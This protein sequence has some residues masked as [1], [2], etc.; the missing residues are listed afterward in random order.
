MTLNTVADS[1]PDEDPDLYMLGLGAT[2][3]GY[4][5]NYSQSVYG[6]AHDQFSM[7]VL[8]GLTKHRGSVM[9]R[10]TDPRDTPVINFRFFGDKKPGEQIDDPHSSDL[11][12]LVKGLKIARRAV[13][14]TWDYKE[15]LP[16]RG[17]A[18]DAQLRDYV[19]AEAWGHHASCTAKI[20]PPT[21]PMAVLDSRFRVYR[22]SGLRVVDAS[23]F[24]QLPNFFPAVAV[25]MLGEKAA[26]VIVADAMT[27]S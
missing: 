4:F 8:K 11:D 25:N 1:R 3:R 2:F 13:T 12:A 10:S 22:T 24:P 17:V 19:L 9:L 7:V 20:G 27:P 26:D 16:G 6:P 21:D 23:A 14:S 5:P 15:V 18:T